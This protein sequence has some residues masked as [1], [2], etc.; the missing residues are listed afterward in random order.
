MINPAKFILATDFDAIANTKD[1][2]GVVSV[3]GSVPAIGSLSGAMTFSTDITITEN[4][5]DIQPYA[6]STLDPSS[7]YLVTQDVLLSRTG[8]T[9]TLGASP[10][11]IVLMTYTPD[12]NII[13]VAV[14]V[15]NPYA[16]ALTL[17]TET[18][19]FSLRGF[20][21]PYAEPF[22]RGTQAKGTISIENRWWALSDPPFGTTLPKYTT[23]AVGDRH[24]V[25]TQSIF[26]PGYAGLASSPTPGVAVCPAMAVESGDEFNI[27][28]GTYMQI[29]GWY[30]EV[31]PPSDW[32]AYASGPF[33]GGGS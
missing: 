32:Q 12:Y 21:P 1:Y 8:T 17:Q 18:V 28:S 23:F 10:Y 11:N 24:Y 26:V 31:P 15:L 5:P 6:V 29:R 27:A 33:S 2:H 20:I 25:L 13:R 4:Y 7:T 30:G 3:S 19:S 22:V 14:K 9:P 16:E